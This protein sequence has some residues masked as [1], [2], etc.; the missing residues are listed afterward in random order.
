[1]PWL[2]RNLLLAVGGVLGAGLLGFAGYFLYARIRLEQQVTE[3]L[4]TQTRELEDLTKQKPHPGNEK[5]NNIK[6][7]E[8]QERELQRFLA[9]ARQ[10]FVLPD[11]PKGLD[12]GQFKLLLDNTVDELQRAAARA[13][14]KIPPQYAFTFAAEKPLM[15][16]EPETIEPLARMLTDIRAICHVIFDAKVLALDGIRR[17]PVATLDTPGTSGGPAEF[18][19]RKPA[20]N[21]LAITVPYELT[22][23]A[24]TPELAAVLEGLYKCPQCFLVKNVVVDTAPSSLLEKQ[25]EEPEMPMLPMTR[26]G[27]SMDFYRM[28]MLMRYGRGRYMP[29]MP[30]VERPAAPPPGPGPGGGVRTVLDEKPFRVIMWVD[31]VRLKAPGESAPPKAPKRGRAP[32]EATQPVAGDTAN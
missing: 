27:G 16:F 9:E 31:V 26:A 1:M 11:Y 6:L 10:T 21:D 14:V 13:K 15:A 29:Q 4:Q 24:F 30:P 20:T 23:H 17:A 28:L 32:A 18:W 7:A 22:F 25:P 3:K 5:V 2:K 8:D 12:S 19:N